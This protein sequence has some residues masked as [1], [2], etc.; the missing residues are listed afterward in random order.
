MGLSLTTKQ[1]KDLTEQEERRVSRFSSNDI[2]NGRVYNGY[3]YRLQVWV[4]NGVITDVGKGGGLVGQ[5]IYD[6]PDAERRTS[7][8]APATSSNPEPPST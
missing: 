6:Q 3:D 8:I 1:R 4:V 5:S 7:V 2:R